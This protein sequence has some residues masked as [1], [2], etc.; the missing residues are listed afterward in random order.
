MLNFFRLQVTH[1]QSSS[2]LLDRSVRFIAFTLAIA[3][4]YG[5]TAVLSV[6]FATLPGKVTAVWLPSGFATA[7]VSLFGMRALPGIA[8]GS[9][10]G[11][12]PDF[13]T[14]NPVPSLPNLIFI[15]IAIAVADCLEPTVNIFILKWLT[16]APPAFNQLRSVVT[17]ILS[18]FT[19]PLISA[20]IGITSLSLIQVS[21]WE[22]YSFSWL[23]W[24]LSTMIS[25]LLFT[26]PLLLWQQQAWSKPR[27]HWIE[28]TLTFGAS[29]GL[30][31]VIF[32]KGYP[33]EY[34]FLPFLMWNVFRSG[35]LFTSLFVSLISIIAIWATARGFGPYVSISPTRSLLLLQSFMAVCST[36]NLV[37]AAVVHE[38]KSAELALAKS[39]ASLEQQVE[40]RTAELQESKA[41]VDGFFSAAPV[42]LGIIDQQFKY[43]QVNQLLADWNGSSIEEHLGQTIQQITPDI[44]TNLGY[45]HQ[46]VLSF[47][48]PILNREETKIISGQ[49]E[50]N[51][52]WLMSYFPILD[53]Q[54]QPSKVGMIVTEISDR[55]RLEI[56]LK[57]QARE[58]Q[59]TTISNRLHF[60]EASEL[61][62]RRCKRNQ[63]PFSLILLDIDEFKKYNDTYGHVAGDACLVQVAK[64][65]L[66]VVGRAGD[67]V[68]RYGG[69]EFI[70]LL[71][72]TDA[73]GAAHVAEL[74]CKSLQEKQIPHGGSVVCGYLTVSLGVATCIPNV[75]L[76]VDDVIQA[77]D[78]A[79]YESKRQ[80]RD[81][82]TT[83]SI[84]SGMNKA[85]D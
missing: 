46:Y 56:Q 79:L 60:K 80:G 2:S 48:Q 31:W 58:D 29:L 66:T 13:L 16:G 33:L 67:L 7:L 36:T 37:L 47:G 43:V 73:M 3:I 53:D 72:E 27:L 55:K 81:R 17:F 45:I 49:P 61:E 76:Q 41:I 23:T 63:K 19:G 20:T 62:W 65:L 85:I 84:V 18:M 40:N 9:I 68:A 12:L 38:R 57:R 75:S 83:V 32:I 78:E 69:E 15:N 22:S 42:G 52:T 44:A 1:Q 14:M 30:S 74:V 59:L 77:A 21:P 25:S 26:P 8:L 6:S 70:I 35:S 50:D 82:L 64:L 71:P 54:Q 39:L 5:I 28:T 4:F 34:I 10:F 24:Y 11:L 51:Q